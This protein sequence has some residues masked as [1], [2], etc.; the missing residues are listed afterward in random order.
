MF[1]LFKVNLFKLIQFW[2]FINYI[3]Q[4]ANPNPFSGRL[5]LSL[6]EDVDS[7]QLE[8]TTKSESIQFM[9]RLPVGARLKH[10]QNAWESVDS[11]AYSVV[12]NGYHIQLHQDVRACRSAQQVYGQS[13]NELKAIDEHVQELIDEG[14][15]EEVT[16]P[17]DL[18]YGVVSSLFCVKKKGTKDLRPCLNLKKFNNFTVYKKFKMEGISTVRELIRPNDFLTKID[19][20]K[21]YHHVPIHPNTRKY[22]QF[23]WR[24][25]RYQFTCLPFGLQSAPRVFTKVLRPVLGIL[26][27]RGIRLVAYLDD[28]LVLSRSR[29]AAV[30]DSNMVLELLQNLGFLINDKKSVLK[31]SKKMEFLGVVINTKRLIVQVPKKKL[32]KFL[33]EAR[34]IYN[35]AKNHKQITI[36]KLAGIIGKLNSMAQAMQGTELHIRGLQWALAEHTSRQPGRHVRWDT[37]IHLH[38]HPHAVQDLEWWSKKAPLWNGRAVM[39][40]NTP[41]KIIYTDA[42]NTGYAGVLDTGRGLQ[43]VTRGFWSSREV[44]QLSIN[45][46]ELL[47]IS[48]T[49]LGLL[50]HR[51]WKNKTVLV[52]TDSL[53]CVWCINKQTSK[54]TNIFHEL[55]RLLFKCRASKIHLV[56]THIPGKDNVVADFE[57]RRFYDCSDWRLNP[58]VFSVLD[59]VW[60]PHTVDWTATRLN[61]QLP[62][63]CSWLYD[64]EA[65]YIDVF[66][67]LHSREN[68]YTNPPFSIIGRLLQLVRIR[69]ATLTIVA[70]VW[71]AQ[72][73]WPMLMAMCIDFPIIISDYNHHHHYKHSPLFIPPDHRHGMNISIPKWEVAAFRISGSSSRCA[74]F[75]Q[76]AELQQ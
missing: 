73:W 50:K 36:R 7:W 43:V 61:T 25:K 55:Q 26:R 29:K 58:S 16:D 20:K 74:R 3:K 48:R 28:I 35:K 67:S 75:R 39:Q 54:G 56:A 42:S 2:L 14:A 57:S 71:R 22:L 63:F 18:K 72:P 68:G 1:C 52:Y 59:S 21:A 65:T 62:R 30:R 23:I 76:W 60:G 64:P 40:R 19:L 38:H 31:P 70:P 17:N 44:E 66:K 51:H 15:V 4:L 11:W 45:A 47:A 10:F 24:K 32:N 13:L 6:I 41:D 49:I 37:H 12:K 27:S 9:P 69:R 53:V 33:K 5:Y 34:Q 8:S 46:R